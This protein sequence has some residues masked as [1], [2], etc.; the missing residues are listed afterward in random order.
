MVKNTFKTYTGDGN[1]IPT[2]KSADVQWAELSAILSRYCGEWITPEYPGA[3]N[4]RIPNTALLGNG[5]IGI[6]SDGSETKKIFR[7][8]KGD[9]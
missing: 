7:I 6:S 8:S 4:P 3:I 9:F 5:N 1:P 2:G